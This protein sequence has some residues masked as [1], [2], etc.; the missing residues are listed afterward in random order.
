MGELPRY[1]LR[2]GYDGRQFRGYQRQPGCRTVEGDILAA[3]KR[4]GIIRDIKKANFRSSSR[5]DA[6]VSALGNIL[7]VNTDFKPE[8]LLAALNSQVEEVWFTGIKK[9]GSGFNPRHAK[10]RVY[11]YYL[12]AR[13]HRITALRTAAKPF[14]GTHDFANFCYKVE[15]K[16]T[17]RT[18]EKISVARKSGMIAI[19]V[20]GQSFLWGMV[21]MIVGAMLAVESGKA[22]VAGVKKALAGGKKVDFGV[23]PAES[24]VL[25]DVAYDFDFE[26]AAPH[27]PGTRDK[28]RIMQ[29]KLHEAAVMGQVFGRSVQELG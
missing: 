25:A 17:V 8:Q 18:V 28:A 22:T 6:G 4:L 13:G 14:E 3:M 29:Q 23:A 15:G 20:R 26:P 2:F 16:N 7:A 5:T 1:A 21:R 24:L 9:V 19:E 10:M 27:H 12:P 11:R